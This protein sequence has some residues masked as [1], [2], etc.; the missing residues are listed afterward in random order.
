MSQIAKTTYKT[1]ADAYAQIWDYLSGVSG[2]A[3]VAVDTLVDITTTAYIPYGAGAASADAALE[4]ELELLDVF[5][6]AYVAVQGIASSSSSLLDAV[7]AV[8]NFVI[9][10]YDTTSGYGGTARTTPDTKLADFVMSAVWSG[11]LDCIPRG[12]YELSE[13]AGYD[14]SSWIGNVCWS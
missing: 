10:N 1:I 7:R 4:L 12:W 6:A 2:Q 9:T 5:N 3:R 14:V 11:P 13:D 8:N